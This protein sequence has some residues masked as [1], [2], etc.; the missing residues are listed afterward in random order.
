M[1]DPATAASIA[2]SLEPT[3]WE[4][5]GTVSRMRD[6]SDKKLQDYI[7]LSHVLK[8]LFRKLRFVRERPGVIGYMLPGIVEC[9]LRVAGTNLSFGSIFLLYY[10]VAASYITGSSNPDEVAVKA[11]SLI[12]QDNPIWYYRA[13]AIVKPSFIRRSKAPLYPDLND[14]VDVERFFRRG[15]SFYHLLRLN[16]NDP[17]SREAVESFVLTRRTYRDV[18]RRLECRIPC[19]SDIDYIHRR[20]ASSRIDFLVYRRAGFERALELTRS[21]PLSERE[22]MGSIADLTVLTLY[23]YSLSCMKKWSCCMEC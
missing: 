12:V 3:C 16:I 13:L 10:N 11:Q 8:D 15:R 18:M 21:K 6:H 17:V 1:Q 23:Y 7:V 9:M 19:S 22:S 5:L 20:L 14:E 2:L 4:G